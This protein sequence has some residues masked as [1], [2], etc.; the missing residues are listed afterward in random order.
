MVEDIKEGWTT[1][2]KSTNTY[3]SVIVRV[4]FLTD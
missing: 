3:I 2:R 1:M 4:V